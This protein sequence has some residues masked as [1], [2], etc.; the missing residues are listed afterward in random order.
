[1]DV[2]LWIR[3]TLPRHG[4]V[5]RD[6]NTNCKY[7]WSSQDQ[8]M[9]TD[10]LLLQKM[11]P[12]LIHLQTTLLVILGLGVIGLP[13]IFLMFSAFSGQGVNFMNPT[14]TTTIAGR[15]RREA[16]SSIFPKINP[17]V[18]NKLLDILDN[19]YKASD[20]VKMFKKLLQN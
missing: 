12:K 5:G 19:F 18:Q 14:T 13:F 20:K 17:Q 1:M 7:T 15:K 8:V 3:I 4:L 2:Q 16:S 6:G 11:C 10:P 9:L